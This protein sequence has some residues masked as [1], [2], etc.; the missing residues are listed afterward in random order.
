MIK[1]EVW[2]EKLKTQITRPIF[3]KGNKLDLNN[4]RP[5]ALLS[6]FDKII[7]KFFV[8]K[9]WNFFEK[10]KCITRSQFGY[11]KKKVQ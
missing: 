2:P 3:K 5:I 8:N 9:I 1:Y 4:Y 7:E 6:V 10:F 11:Q